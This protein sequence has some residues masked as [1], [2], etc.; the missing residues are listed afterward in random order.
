M[1][2]ID[3]PGGSLDFILPSET[4]GYI[5]AV[6]VNDGGELGDDDFA[7]T[8]M[9]PYGFFT[10]KNA[11]QEAEEFGRRHIAP[12]GNAWRVL[13]VQAATRSAPTPP[14]SMC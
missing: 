3:V 5:V 12:V 7:P 2:S 14:C 6:F 10:G 13:P 4:A 1:I 9:L 11:R 8:E